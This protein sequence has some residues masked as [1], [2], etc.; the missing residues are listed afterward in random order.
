MESHFITTAVEILERIY[1]VEVNQEIF[2]VAEL[3][4]RKCCGDSFSL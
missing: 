4:E 1:S 2:G 3:G